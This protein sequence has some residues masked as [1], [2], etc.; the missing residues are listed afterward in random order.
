MR[1]SFDDVR[2]R[3]TKQR[4]GRRC[5]GIDLHIPA[6]QSVALVGQTGAG[7]ST[8]VKLV[9]RFYDPTSGAVLRRRRDCAS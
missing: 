5:P 1:S 9:A 4:H 7:K 8:L 6:G 3:A 2:L